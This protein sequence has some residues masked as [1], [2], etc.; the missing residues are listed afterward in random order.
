[1]IE[2]DAYEQIVK[3]IEADPYYFAE[4]KYTEADMIQKYGFGRNGERITHC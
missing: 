4:G 2:N 1:M 3:K